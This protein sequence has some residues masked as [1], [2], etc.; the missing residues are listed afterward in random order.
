MPLPSTED[1]ISDNSNIVPAK[2][3]A[4]TAKKANPV[5]TA[6]SP[7]APIVLTLPPID[8]ATIQ[9]QPVVALTM[10][11]FDTKMKF[12]IKDWIYSDVNHPVGK[13]L[14]D[15][16]IHT[17]IAFQ[18]MDPTVIQRLDFESKAA[19]TNIPAIRKNLPEQYI[20][21]IRNTVEYIQ[22][23]EATGNDALADDPTTW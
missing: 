23:L 18:E 20:I 16:Y 17:Y 11:Q 7:A 21:K 14:N 8:T 12:I 10:A 2:L 1:Y 19:T 15:Q 5:V 3:I 4:S 6:D 13:A 9:A 22:Y